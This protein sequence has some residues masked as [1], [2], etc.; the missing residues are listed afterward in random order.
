MN[1]HPTDSAPAEP[2]VEPAPN[3]HASHPGFSGLSGLI[4]AVSF[5]SGRDEA[6]DLAIELSGLGPGDHL[7]DIGCGPGVAA[8]RARAVGAEVVGVDPA[9]VMLRV[10]RLRWRNEPGIDWRIGVAESV[11]AANGWAQ[12]VWS[13]AT[14]HHWADVDAGLTEA[15][16]MLA[17]GGRLVVLERRIE[18]TNAAGKASHG[19]TPDQAESFAELC[20]RHGFHD[21][22]TAMHERRQTL[23]SVV[24]HA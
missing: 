20:R 5:L 23:L 18:D 9:T 24:A 17:L 1:A 16:R 7:V 2:N 22:T 21:V 6:A 14:V 13:L 15:R 10:A 19:W 3:H 4:A 12:V 8:H 11:P